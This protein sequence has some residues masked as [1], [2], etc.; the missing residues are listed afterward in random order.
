MGNRWKIII[1]L[2]I[3]IGVIVVAKTVERDISRTPSAK[4]QV[5][6]RP[7]E[8]ASSVDHDPR[9]NLGNNAP[10]DYPPVN[11]EPDWQGSDYPPEL[12]MPPKEYVIGPD[13]TDPMGQPSLNEPF[14]GRIEPILGPDSNDPNIGVQPGVDP[15]PTIDPTTPPV[16]PRPQPPVNQDPPVK[17]DPPPTP[18]YPKQHEVLEGESLWEIA[19]QHYGRGERFDR[20]LAA[21]PDLGD[22]EFLRAGITITIPAP[23]ASDNKAKKTQSPPP[24]GMVRYKIREGD[25][26]YGI[27]RDRLGSIQ[28][29]DE[30]LAANPGLDPRELREGKTILIPRE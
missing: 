26:F 4:E 3:I 7:L 5:G 19:R 2:G 27:A 1:V 13:A 12:D 20:I 18:G 24:A 21:N 8:I 23:K 29:V 6:G 15:R 28:R 22:G 16:D 14:E 30:I 11:N 25:T 9:R 17:K 10:V